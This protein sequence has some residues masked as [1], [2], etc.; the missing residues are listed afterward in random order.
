MKR[1]FLLFTSLLLLAMPVPTRTQPALP[2]E[3]EWMTSRLEKKMPALANAAVLRKVRASRQDGYDR[4]VFEFDGDSVPDHWVEYKRPPFNL[5]ESDQIVKVPGR[6]FVSVMFRPAVGYNP[7]TGEKVIEGPEGRLRL[8]VLRALT[9]I[10][11]YEGDV[12]Y[13]LGLSARK[14]FRVQALTNP[15]RLAV[16]IKH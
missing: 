13:I 1:I 8:T 4:V 14:P 12:I 6:A 10:Y 7:D 16:D 15:A 2:Q 9:N 5:G 11:D 3:P